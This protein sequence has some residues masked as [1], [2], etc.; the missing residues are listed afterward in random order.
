MR[1]LKITNL[2][3]EISSLNTQLTDAETQIDELHKALKKA[4][5]S[6]T[7]MFVL[8]GLIGIMIIEIVAHLF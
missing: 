7:K 3:F 5:N 1:L 6:A 2:K 8:G 4:F